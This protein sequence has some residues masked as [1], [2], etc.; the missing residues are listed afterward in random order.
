MSTGY[1]D[2][3][4]NGRTVDL[5]LNAALGSQTT[6]ARFEGLCLGDQLATVNG[7]VV[8][9]APTVDI[10]RRASAERRNLILAREHPLYLHGGLNYAYTSEGLLQEDPAI[11]FVP[12]GSDRDLFA[13]ERLS[14]DAVV[15][16]KR[17]IAFDGELVIY[18]HGAAWDHYRPAAQSA[19]LARM[20]GLE[21]PR[22]QEVA[23]RRGVVCQL[24]GAATMTALARTAHTKLNSTS[25]RIV[26]DSDLVVHRAAVLAGETDPVESLADLLS[27]PLVD[28]VVAGG[29]GILDEVDGGIAYFLDVMGTGRRV[30]MLTV[31]YG[32]S[33]EP[34]VRE[35]ADAMRSIIPEL[36]VE[37]W[38]SGDPSWIPGEQ[39]GKART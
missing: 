6:V 36:D 34:G 39:D 3:G 31:G 5:M 1:I 22:E 4:L 33:H 10:L 14:G 11:S 12:A 28:C 25:P 38:P 7:A 16:A 23:R 37:Y 21:V 32:P 13:T 35:M 8:C 18:R 24:Q 29:G 26:G 9:Y 20:L 17:A 27:D 15:A 19:A 30:A 2:R